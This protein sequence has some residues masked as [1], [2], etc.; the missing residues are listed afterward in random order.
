MGDRPAIWIGEFCLNEDKVV[1]LELVGQVAQ[2]LVRLQKCQKKLENGEEVVDYKNKVDDL[3]ESFNET[4]V[5]LDNLLKLQ[6]ACQRDQ[7]KLWKKLKDE[8]V[9]VIARFKL[10]QKEVNRNGNDDD[11]DSDSEP[12]AKKTKNTGP[13][14]KVP[15]DARSHGIGEPKQT[16]EDKENGIVLN[17]KGADGTEND[18][19]R[20]NDP[21]QPQQQSGDDKVKKFD[22]VNVLG[23]SNPEQ[24]AKSSSKLPSTTN[25]GKTLRRTQSN[26][27]DK[28]V[29]PKPPKC[30][31]SGGHSNAGHSSNSV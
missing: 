24:G 3:I 14:K 18:E 10:R 5:D 11:S 26:T 19:S 23:S 12:K 31:S 25:K 16:M 17:E 9:S 7:N 20:T 30:S 22:D 15:K 21:N 2:E 29:S 13:A 1:Y 27:M 6:N 28:Y 8:M 4:K